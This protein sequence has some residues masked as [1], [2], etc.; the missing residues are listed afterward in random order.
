MDPIIVKQAPEKDIEVVT[1]LLCELYKGH[2]YEDL[3]AEN[4]ALLSS[5]KQVFFL[6]YCAETPVG[7]CHGALREEYVNGK[8]YDSAAGYLEAIYV[9]P[10]YRQRGAAAALVAACEDWA[11]QSGCREFLSDCR[12]D[13]ADSYFFHQRLGFTETERCVFF[14]KDILRE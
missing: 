2:S 14:R 5:R 1:Q 12:L 3:L 11:R 6:A 9:R 10:D 8:E 7:C 13:N 4:K